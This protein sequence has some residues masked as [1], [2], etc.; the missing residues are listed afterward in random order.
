M[1]EELAHIRRG[2][3][4]DAGAL[5]E[6][7]LRARA[8]AV[9]SGSIPRSVHSEEDVHSWMAQVVL[10]MRDVWLAERRPGHILGLL[11]LDGDWV[12]Q[13]Y[14]DPDHLGHGI[15]SRLL[16]VAKRERPQGLRLWTF[17]SNPGAQRFYARHGFTEVLRTDGSG[18]EE[19]APDIQL[20]WGQR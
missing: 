4:A 11:V 16:E 3:A 1:G 6:L 14:V 15:G 10:E 2:R 9:V 18:N 13:L 17:V 7:Y 19:R 12:D 20:A 8:A 5:S